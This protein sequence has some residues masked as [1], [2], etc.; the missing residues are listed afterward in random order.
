MS[1]TLTV[2]A[3]K[4]K[5][6]K[7]IEVKRKETK[8][9]I[10]QADFLLM[11][12]ALNHAMERD[13]ND[14]GEGYFIRSLYFD[15]I[16]NKAFEEKMAGIEKRKKFR[17]RLYDIDSAKVKLEIKNKI[18]D[19]ILK[20]SIWISR[21][22]AKEMQEGNYDVLLNYDN[23]V[24]R[25]VF[26][27][28]KRFCY[29]PVV[30]IDYERH[31]FVH[32]FNNIR[33]TFDSRIRANSIDL[34]MFDRKIF[35]KPLMAQQLVVLEIKF[36]RFMPEWLKSVLRMKNTNSAISK[37]CIGRIDNKLAWI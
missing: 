34:N 25:K 6:G 32:D 12:S 24:A 11:S 35:M 22:D 7:S 29:K 27:E 20:Q 26:A 23:D 14:K 2:E 19:C 17:L 8:F 15:T 36:D 31:A 3:N 28:F 33:V 10:S 18:N 1:K 16:E 4:V 21:K 30:I 5:A 13:G 9:F 37:Y